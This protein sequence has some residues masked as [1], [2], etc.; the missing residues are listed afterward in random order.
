MSCKKEVY[1]SG[2]WRHSLAK[3]NYLSCEQ[4]NSG[5]RRKR[6]KKGADTSNCVVG[7][8]CIQ[9]QVVVESLLRL[10]IK[11]AHQRPQGKH[12]D[13]GLQR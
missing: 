9:M 2:N 13:A 11:K 10:I 7:V 8:L 4:F 5:R 1:C 3:Q 12:W 6:R